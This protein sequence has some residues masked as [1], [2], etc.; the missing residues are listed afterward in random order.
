MNVE[1]LTEGEK[2]S[3]REHLVGQRGKLDMS[4]L[5]DVLFTVETKD[6]GS[7]RFRRYRVANGYEGMF[8]AAVRTIFSQSLR[9]TK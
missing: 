7:K 4:P 6:C 8:A 3:I 1:T 9:P 2:K 5:D